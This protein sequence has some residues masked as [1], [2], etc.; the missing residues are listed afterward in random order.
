MKSLKLIGIA[1]ALLLVFLLTTCSNEDPAGAGETSNE[2]PVL[3]STQ[4]ADIIDLPVW[5]ETVG[6]VH[7][8]SAPTL[9]A[10]IEGRI[11]MVAVDTGDSIEQGQL[12]AETDTS[13]LRLQKQAAQAGIDRLDVHI[14]NGERRVD[15]FEKL[16]SKNLS[17][18]SQLDDAREQ[19]EAYRADRKAAVTQLAMVEDS[20]AKSRI[21]TP[22]FR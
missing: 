16:S 4:K 21:V 9:A 5:L 11:T 1:T 2:K 22:G 20:L 7:S 8:L 12:L 6:Q 17:S 10:E 13:T 14:A 18:Q 15:R 19:L 3:I